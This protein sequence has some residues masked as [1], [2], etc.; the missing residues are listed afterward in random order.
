MKRI[1]LGVW[2][3]V[4]AGC[5]GAGSG[6]GVDPHALPEFGE[7]TAVPGEAEPNDDPQNESVAVAKPADRTFAGQ[8]LQL[9]D[10]AS[11]SAERMLDLFERDRELAASVAGARVLELGSGTGLAGLAAVVLGAQSV[12]FT[13]QAAVMDV[14]QA[15]ALPNL[16]AAQRARV[17]FDVLQWG[18][19][20]PD[21][22]L[23]PTS[24]GPRFDIIIGAD[25]VYAREAMQPLIHTI[26]R[27][28]GRHAVTYLAYVQRFPWAREFFVE[29]AHSHD[30]T[31]IDL[32]NGVW[33]FRFQ[34]R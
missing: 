15:N 9:P 21:H 3:L 32:G 12:A 22:P 5:A 24:S 19:D 2:L 25:L 6:S 31:L 30:R 20:D 18:T 14:L 11:R 34:P 29:M 10:G 7:R 28:G 13:D 27:F 1:V 16:T 4:A 33:I 17:R 8:R 26:R 23:A